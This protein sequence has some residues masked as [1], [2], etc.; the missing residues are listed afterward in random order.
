[1]QIKKKNENTMREKNKR[2]NSY[3]L[4]S[5]YFY[6]NEEFSIVKSSAELFQ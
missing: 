1:M 2:L 6:V 4:I 3:V 5:G